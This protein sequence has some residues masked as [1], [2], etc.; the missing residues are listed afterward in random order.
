MLGVD[1]GET[2][3]TSIYLQKSASIQPRTSPSKFGEKLFNIIHSCPKD[4]AEAREVAVDAVVDEAPHVPQVRDAF[5]LD[6]DVAGEV[7]DRADAEGRG[8]EGE[9]DI[10]LR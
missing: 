10:H 3:P 5:V 6:Q 9:V 8:E 7:K 2:F 4:R 1:L